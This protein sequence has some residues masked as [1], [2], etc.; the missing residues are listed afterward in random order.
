MS[1][2]A[3]WTTSE[4]KGKLTRRA[5]NQVRKFC[6]QRTWGA[7]LTMP[8]LINAE[9]T[10]YGR[11][12]K[13]H[14]LALHNL[15][16]SLISYYA[17]HTDNEGNWDGAPSIPVWTE[18][19]L[20]SEIADDDFPDRIDCP[21][22]HLKA[23]DWNWQ[24]LQILNLLKWVKQTPKNAG[25]GFSTPP[26]PGYYDMY[27]YGKQGTILSYDEASWLPI[28]INAR[29][30]T[31]A[32]DYGIKRSSKFR[33][34]LTNGNETLNF[35]FDLYVTPTILT[36]GPVFNLHTINVLNKVLTETDLIAPTDFYY[37]GDHSESPTFL[38][39]LYG[40]QM[41]YILKFDIDAG[42][43]FLAA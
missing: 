38:N 21:N 41:F 25:H 39:T 33:I 4:G 31:W 22:D 42:F 18:S 1:L 20:L 7:G 14:R 27:H 6:E 19:A 3:N 43:D 40:G 2:D 30:R 15:V 24:T 36:A 12:T 23:A 11:V 8:A 37:G 26:A 16:S 28:S 9:I 35:D 29:Y 10:H 17:N 34:M 5:F 13:A 32:F